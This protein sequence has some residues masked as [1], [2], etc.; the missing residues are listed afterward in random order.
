MGVYGLITRFNAVL[1]AA[2]DQAWKLQ[3]EKLPD[4]IDDDEQAAIETGIANGIRLKLFAEL[5]HATR[6]FAQ[7][8]LLE[9][10]ESARRSLVASVA[11]LEHDIGLLRLNLNES[12]ALENFHSV[13]ILVHCAAMFPKY[14]LLD[15][16]VE[17]WDRIQA[18]NLRGTMLVMREAIRTMRAGGKGGAIVNVSSVS[19][20]REVVFHNAAYGASK[21]GT[22]NLTRVAALEFGCDNIRVNAVLP[23]GTATEGAREA[24]E[25]MKKSVAHVEQFLERK[26]GVTKGKVV[27]EG[28]YPDAVMYEL[29]ARDH[30]AEKG[31]DWSE[32]PYYGLKRDGTSTEGPSAHIATAS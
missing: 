21:A 23:G 29:K 11:Q 13:D 2:T 8:R 9:G 18:V 14:A 1:A 15:V 20:E 32:A 24:T 22:T 27:L 30:R 3:K 10:D 16:T 4:D 5:E 26:A 25:V 28:R 31:E 17:Q 12:A 19:G 7:K 6:D